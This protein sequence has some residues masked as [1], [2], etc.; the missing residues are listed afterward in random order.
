MY[1]LHV[2]GR[3]ALQVGVVNYAEA[4][5]L[6]RVAQELSESR[7]NLEGVRLEDKIEAASRVAH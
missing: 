4:H 6:V 7:R 1:T 2:P 3:A 5:R